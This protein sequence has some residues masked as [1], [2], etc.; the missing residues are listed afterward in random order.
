MSMATRTEID[1]L[2]FYVLDEPNRQ[3]F[4]KNGLGSVPPE[5]RVMALRGLQ[6]LGWIDHHGI[7]DYMESYSLTKEGRRIAAA[8]P[9]LSSMSK[10]AIDHIEAIRALHSTSNEK[11]IES[12]KKLISKECDLGNWDSALMYCHEL[13]L[14]GEQTKEPAVTAFAYSHQGRVEVSQNHW[15]EALESYLNAIEKYMDAGDRKGVCATNRAMGVIYG[16]KGDHASAIRCFESSLSLAKAIGDR[17]AEAMAH[18][19]LAIIYD[20][21]GRLDESESASRSCLE[22]FMEIGDLQKAARASNN[23]G[24]LKLSR[25]RFQEAV[26]YFDKTIST[27]RMTKNTDVLGAALVNAGYCHARTGSLDPAIRYTDEAVTIFKEANDLNML[28]LSYRNYG[29]IEFRHG[30]HEK[31]F[32]WFDK[33]VRTASASGVEDT[34]AAC[35]YEYGLALIRSVTSLKLAKKLLTKSAKTYRTIG[36]SLRAR[37]AELALTSA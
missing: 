26:E 4:L 11:K 37:E 3:L 12:L 24:V 27:S 33:S 1:T 35:C 20:L 23:L 13:R 5:M 9:E 6:D 7:A 16:S 22:Y 34:Y 18:G 32:Q 8:K 25:D 2:I 29:V 15:D 10:C 30:N 14:L 19:N 36:N 21:E 31:A 17:D 28:A